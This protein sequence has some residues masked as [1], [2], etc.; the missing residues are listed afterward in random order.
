MV[1]VST[2]TMLDINPRDLFFCGINWN[3]ASLLK[4]HSAVTRSN[5]CLLDTPI[6]ASPCVPHFGE[7]RQCHTVTQGSVTS[8]SHWRSSSAVSYSSRK[9]CYKLP[10]DCPLDPPTFLHLHHPTQVEA[11]II[12]ASSLGF[13]PLFFHPI[14]STPSRV[15]FTNSM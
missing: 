8:P 14:L 11:T 2:V 15:A 9:P 13:P 3:F 6:P 5:S 7:R 4:H 10:P 1:W 12:P